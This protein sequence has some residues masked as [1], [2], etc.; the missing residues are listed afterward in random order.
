MVDLLDP[1]DR[2]GR[3]LARGR[4]RVTGR[5]RTPVTNPRHCESW[6][7]LALTGSADIAPETQ[8]YTDLGELPPARLTDGRKRRPATG[9]AARVRLARTACHFPAVLAGGVKSVNSWEFAHQRLPEGDGEAAWVCTRAGTWRGTGAR[10]MAQFQPPAR[11]PG[12]PGAA[13]SRAEDTPACGPRGREVVSGVLWK[14]SEGHWYVLAAA[15][16]EVPEVRVHGT[17]LRPGH[18]YGGDDDGGRDGAA[19]SGIRAEAAGDSGADAGGSGGGSGGQD[20]EAADGT[21]VTGSGTLAV[22]AGPGVR[23]ELSGKRADGT[24]VPPLG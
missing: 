24:R 5:L 13:A 2:E 22:P 10:V 3:T 1:A 11:S 6:P 23:A 17:G 7:G 16:D 20:G 9:E 19:G 18:A 8:L 14:S 4:D 12:R 21:T 15:S